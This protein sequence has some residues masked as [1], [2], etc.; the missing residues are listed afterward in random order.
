MTNNIPFGYLIYL[1]IKFQSNNFNDL[2]ETDSNNY[3][4]DYKI[5]FEKAIN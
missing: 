5:K 3:N 4:E 1:L 2:N